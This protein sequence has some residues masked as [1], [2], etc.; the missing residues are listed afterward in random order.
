MSTAPTP[1]EINEVVTMSRRENN[2]SGS[3][4]SAARRSMNTNATSSAPPSPN[5]PR[6]CH[7]SHSQACP[8]SSTARITSVRPTVST[9][10]PAKSMR[11]FSRPTDSW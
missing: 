6:L 5:A 8:P 7:D 11:C 4:G 2:H 9:E 10:A 1:S 3:I